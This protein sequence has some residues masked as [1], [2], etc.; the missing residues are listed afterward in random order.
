MI[1]RPS[2]LPTERAACF[3]MA[4]TMPWR[5]FVPPLPQGFRRVVEQQM[6]LVEKEDHPGLF[7][8]ADFRQVLE[9]LR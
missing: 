5:R 6:R 2:S 9:Q 1:W 7:K 3:A 4:S 8:V